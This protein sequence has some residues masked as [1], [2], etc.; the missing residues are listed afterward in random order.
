MSTRR[1]P[2]GAEVSSDG[3][4]FRVWAPRRKSVEVVFESDSSGKHV[5][6]AAEAG[7]Y[8]SGLAAGTKAGALYRF[9]LDD[10]D[11]LF[12]DPV[13]RFQPDGVHGPSQ[14]IDPNAFKWTDDNWQAPPFPAGV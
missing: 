2:V 1:L 9:R 13:S 7:G 8:F 4:H 3:V 6:L 12:P 10:G 14:V 5:Q 11:K